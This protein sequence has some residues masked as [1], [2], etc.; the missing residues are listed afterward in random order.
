MSF[1]FSFLR[2]FIARVTF[3]ADNFRTDITRHIKPRYN[4]ILY[5]IVM[6]LRH[7]YIN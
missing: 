2:S 6:T 4:E 1:T 3:L 7:V 5:L